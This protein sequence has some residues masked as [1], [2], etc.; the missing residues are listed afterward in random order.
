MKPASTRLLNDGHWIPRLGFGTWPLDDDEA[1][2]AV[3]AAL[4]A[5]YRLIDTASRYGNETGV[6]RCL[7]AAGLPR[8]DV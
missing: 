4:K 7:Q 1:A 3:E 2:V 8:S 6:G 5:G